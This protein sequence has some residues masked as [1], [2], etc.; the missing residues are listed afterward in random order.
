MP[1]FFFQYEA[2]PRITARTPRGRA[3]SPIPRGSGLSA[4]RLANAYLVRKDRVGFI[5]FGACRGRRWS[6]R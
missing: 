6:L 1:V 5:E 2:F 3:A 4:M